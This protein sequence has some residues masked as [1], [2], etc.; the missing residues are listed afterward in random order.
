[1]LCL[2]NPK[3]KFGKDFLSGKRRIQHTFYTY[4]HVF[5]STEYFERKLIVIHSDKE[6]EK[7]EIQTSGS[8]QFIDHGN[9][10]QPKKK[11][12]TA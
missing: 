1:M 7:A 4:I 6:T 10:Q 12:R 5:T 11:S 2:Q 3:H 9:L 8:N